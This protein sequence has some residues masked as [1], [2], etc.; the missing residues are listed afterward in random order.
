L[1][2]KCIYST[3][4]L[5]GY[6]IPL[7]N[8]LFVISG[9]AFVTFFVNIFLTWLINIVLA[10]FF[11]VAFA[12]KLKDLPE[13]ISGIGNKTKV[14]GVIASAFICEQFG[15]MLYNFLMIP[16]QFS[17]LLGR[18]HCIFLFTFAVTI[19]SFWFIF[20]LLSLSYNQIIKTL[21]SCRIRKNEI[22]LLLSWFILL[23]VF[24]T[25]S[26]SHS[27]AFYNNQNQFALY[28]VIYTSDSSSLIGGNAFFNVNHEENDI[29]Q[30]LFAVFAI[31]FSS[32]AMIFSKVLFFIP[33]SYA[34]NIAI[35]QVLLLGVSI[36]L[37]SRMITRNTITGYLF[38][39]FTS[40]T[41]TFLLFSVMIEQFVF[42]FFW[43]TICLYATFYKENDVDF[44]FIAAFGSLL[45]S[46]ALFPL[47]IKEIDFT[48]ASKRLL[49]I[50]F[51]FVGGMVIFNRQYILVTAV[52][53]IQQLMDFYGASISIQSRLLQYINFVSGVFFAPTAAVD[54][55]SY[56]HI[57]YQLLPVNS[58][59]WLGIYILIVSFLG[60]ALNNK[61]I[62]AQVCLG[63]EIY[64]FLILC[65]VGWGTA[66]NGLII[67]SLYFGW[68]FIVL[69]FMAINSIL[70]RIHI[71][72]LKIVA[73]CSISLL[74]LFINGLGMYDL[75]MF[76]FTYYP[77]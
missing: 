29:R 44:Y 7:L 13:K 22:I 45:T 60:F 55:I 51:G 28:N 5:F 16:S 11:L 17:L 4:S 49:T 39:V 65:L 6:K 21:Q 12:I 15:M 57:S 38:F 53:D 19:T 74:L 40:L 46:I 61:S 31:P 67:Y 70:D 33:N 48:N 54:Y 26:F 76:A 62:L 43:L 37:L 1:K 69:V 42:P 25:W 63:W 32:I 66:E 27:N 10:M 3:F 24:V 58:I 77:L 8:I 50:I 35:F 30:P 72:Q 71:R 41:Y 23:S 9:L 64:S 47:I 18:F 36:L 59:N 75:I 68:A 73:F 14:I 56:E 20:V 52:S 34:L 2:G